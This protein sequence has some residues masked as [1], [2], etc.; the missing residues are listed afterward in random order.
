MSNYFYTVVWRPLSEVECLITH[1]VL[2]V[3]IDEGIISSDYVALYTAQTA[4]M[5]GDIIHEY[6]DQ[7]PV[8][9]QATDAARSIIA[10]GYI[11]EAIF[12]GHQQ[13]V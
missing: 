1:V 11:I 13:S 7:S 9:D 3:A 2:P 12:P 8:E 6:D 10:E 5:S 4:I